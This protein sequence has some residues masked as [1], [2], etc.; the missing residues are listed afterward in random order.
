MGGDEVMVL[1]G[2]SVK[3]RFN[4]EERGF[5]VSF[6]ARAARGAENGADG[7]R[8]DVEHC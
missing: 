5:A 6:I 1:G 8:D 4:R 2:D 7:R 3:P